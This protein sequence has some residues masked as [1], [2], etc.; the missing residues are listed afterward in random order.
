MHVL[1]VR[2]APQGSQRYEILVQD[3][4]GGWPFWV[5]DERTLRRGTG[6]RRARTAAPER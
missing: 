1:A 6:L 4:D 2:V 5:T 3:P